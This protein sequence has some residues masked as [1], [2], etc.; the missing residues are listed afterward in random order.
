MNHDAEIRQILERML[1]HIGSHGL[2]YFSL[3]SS[4][5]QNEEKMWDFLTSDTLWG[6][7]G[8]IADQALLGLPA[9]R[10]LESILIELGRLQIKMDRTNV[11]TNM[12]VSSFEKL[13][14]DASNTTL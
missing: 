9:R 11:R 14:A 7:A 6:G 4:C 13:H 10:K 2:I 8:S 3:D 12:W 5:K 1:E